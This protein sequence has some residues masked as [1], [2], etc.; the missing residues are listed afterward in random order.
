LA[1]GHPVIDVDAARRKASAENA[2]RAIDGTLPAYHSSASLWEIAI[3]PIFSGRDSFLGGR[4]MKP[5]AM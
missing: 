2:A 5:G 1:A 4:H 3:N